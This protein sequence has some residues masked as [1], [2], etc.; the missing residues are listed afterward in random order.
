M[1]PTE[2]SSPAVECLGAA[3]DWSAG[4][5]RPNRPDSLSPSR[6]LYSGKQTMRRI[7]ISY[8]R[9]D[10][11]PQAGRLADRLTQEFGPD[12]VFLDLDAISAGQ[13]FPS[14]I[15]SALAA[16]DVALVLIGPQ[17]QRAGESDGDQTGESDWVRF[18]VAAALRRDDVRVIPVLLEGAHIPAPEDLPDELKPLTNRNA[19]RLS[20]LRWNSEVSELIDALKQVVSPPSNASRSSRGASSSGSH[21]GPRFHRWA[22]VVGAVIAAVTGGALLMLATR[23]NE[24]TR[25]N[26]STVKAPRPIT[27][28]TSPAR[29]PK[30]LRYT[31]NSLGYTTRLPI[32]GWRPGR[33][34]EINPGLF[35]TIIQGPAGAR[36][37]LDFSP[38]ERARFDA[39]GRTIVSR[40]V[41][42]HPTF[43]PVTR[44]VF[45]HGLP[46]CERRLC[47]DY[48]VGHHVPGF[49]A[50]VMA[51]SLITADP[52]ARSLIASLR[53][54]RAGLDSE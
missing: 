7:F 25:A 21:E 31:P 22:W 34:K 13:H 24:P 9:G 5:L 47:V 38:H 23:G 32:T 27:S 45:R 49:G 52:V 53:R 15:E 40:Q 41:L 14:A 37:W 43:G 6:C 18:E 16:S 51:D 54:Y 26:P 10:T 20:S 42:K 33:E 1:R 48:V 12:S 8:R 44:Y 19:F 11:T 28:P 46:G 30:Y 50:L 2:H 35:R 3:S 29:G 36:V 4:D 17:W 39:T